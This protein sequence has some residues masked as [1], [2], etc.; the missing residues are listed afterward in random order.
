MVA[1]SAAAAN[2]LSPFGVTCVLTINPGS[3]ARASGQ[4]G[5]GEGDRGAGGAGQQG[6]VSPCTLADAE[7]VAMDEAVVGA[8]GLVR[9]PG[10]YAV[11]DAA[12][13]IQFVGLATHVAAHVAV[14]W[15]TLPSQHT[16]FVKVTRLRP[17]T[18][19]EVGAALH[20]GAPALASDWELSFRKRW[21]W[22][23]LE[24]RA[25]GQRDA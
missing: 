14:H 10:V 3:Q 12:H 20:T 25:I 2:Q 24:A 4:G 15:Q 13:E 6:D 8:A 7:E 18:L 16:A 11:L 22:A 5:A 21:A 19:G 9:G 17:P 23:F 1:A